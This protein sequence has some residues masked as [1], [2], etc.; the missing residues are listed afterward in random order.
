MPPSA[1]HP[2]LTPGRD[3]WGRA[4]SLCRRRRSTGRLLTA[5]A[6]RGSLCALTA[7]RR[8]HGERRALSERSLA[9]ETS[10]APIGCDALL[11]F[12]CPGKYNL[13]LDLGTSLAIAPDDTGVRGALS[14]RRLGLQ[15][16]TY[17]EVVC[18]ATLPAAPTMNSPTLR[19][20]PPAQ[21]RSATATCSRLR[22]TWSA[23]SPTTC[24]QTPSP[25]PL[26]RCGTHKLAHPA[27]V[28]LFRTS[29]SGCI[30]LLGTRV[31]VRA[32]RAQLHPF[33]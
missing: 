6:A 20:P 9:T 13:L 30:G 29:D 17:K 24:S 8:P 33:P 3:P 31:G 14:L 26:A 27:S 18:G 11:R 23:R 5:M 21:Q 10:A 25:Q 28:E 16:V 19:R 2:P 15:Q 7:R 32:V 1:Q 12:L 22:R 4:V